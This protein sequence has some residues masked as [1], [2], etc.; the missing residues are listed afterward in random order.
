LPPERDDVAERGT[1]IRKVVPP[2]QVACTEEI[3]ERREQRSFSIPVA[4]RKPAAGLLQNTTGLQVVVLA[5]EFI[6]DFE[7]QSPDIDS[8]HAARPRHAVQRSR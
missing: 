6:H 2:R 4:A 3:V 5:D 7:N 8:L 1:G